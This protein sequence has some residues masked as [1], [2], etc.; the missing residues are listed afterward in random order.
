MDP[1]QQPVHALAQVLAAY[2]N[3]LPARVAT[4]LAH[5]SRGATGST[6]ADAG[7]VGGS[8]GGRSGGCW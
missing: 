2:L 8:V 4:G 6:S 3:C 5:R 1:L 7:S